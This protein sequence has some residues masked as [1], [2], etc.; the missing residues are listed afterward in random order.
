MHDKRVKEKRE[1]DAPRGQRAS[2]LLLP[3]P[4][5]VFQ[6]A[7]DQAPV[8]LH[9]P[10]RGRLCC[11]TTNAPARQPKTTIPCLTAP[12]QQQPSHPALLLPFACRA[13]R[14]IAHSACQHFLAF[15]RWLQACLLHSH[16][17]RCLGL[18]RLS[19]CLC[20]PL[21]LRD[22]RLLLD[23]GRRCILLQL[24]VPAGCKFYDCSVQPCK[25][26]TMVA[27]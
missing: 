1:R 10:S 21:V 8:L 13:T 19:I 16:Q 25:I 20:S 6:R 26:E 24:L 23:S 3:K 9:H 17:R 11:K 4:V 12:A 27:I 22:G 7:Q 18:L 14:G 5:D 2:T 15:Q